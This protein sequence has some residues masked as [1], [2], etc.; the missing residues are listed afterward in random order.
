MLSGIQANVE[1]KYEHWI[2]RNAIIAR[3]CEQDKNVQ[4]R[5]ERPPDDK[6][7]HTGTIRRNVSYTFHANAPTASLHIPLCITT[8]ETPH[9]MKTTNKNDDNL[10]KTCT[11]QCCRFLLRLTNN[12]TKYLSLIFAVRTLK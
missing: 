6:L 1:V 12:C 4:G 2:W 9:C 3:R 8:K 11:V 7:A 10:D 5:I